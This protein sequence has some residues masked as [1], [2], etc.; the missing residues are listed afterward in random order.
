MNLRMRGSLFL[1]LMTAL[2]IVAFLL[3]IDDNGAM[4]R[5]R[6]GGGRSSSSGSRSSSKGSWSSSSGSRTSSSGSRSSSSGSWS[7]FRGS[8]WPHLGRGGVVGRGVYYPTKKQKLRR[9][10]RKDTSINDF[11]DWNEMR[12][13][14]GMLCR[15]DNDCKWIDS[16]LYC[17]NYEIDF[18]PDWRWFGGHGARITGACECMSGSFDRYDL[19]CN[20]TH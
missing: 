15:N 11:D 7:S 6:G 19:E 10:Y 9:K 8:R 18:L 4:A 1:L 3:D 17:K 2:V 14:D 12:E 5:G 13:K 16:S 20:S